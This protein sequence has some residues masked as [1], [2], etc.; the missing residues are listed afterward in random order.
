MSRITEKKREKAHLR[1]SRAEQSRRAGAPSISVSEK[2]FRGMVACSRYLAPRH[3]PIGSVDCGR[4]AL[5][6]DGVEGR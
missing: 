4:Q 1:A 5:S 2:A 3:G 6:S